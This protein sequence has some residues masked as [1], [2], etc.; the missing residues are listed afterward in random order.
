M[1][2]WH[3]SEVGENRIAAVEVKA[4]NE[5][6]PFSAPKPELLLK[7]ILEL[8]TNPGDLV[9]DSFAGSGTLVPSRIRWDAGG[10]WSSSVSI[11]T[12]TSSRA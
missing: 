5:N 2:V 9:L 7:R 3:Y 6:D 1:T 8:S 11:A 10:S 12:H 4:F